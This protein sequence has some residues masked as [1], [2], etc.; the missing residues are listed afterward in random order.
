VHRSRLVGGLA[1]GC[2]ALALLA[3]AADAAVPHTV[4]PGETLWSIAA[5]NNYTTRT[6]AAYNGLSEDAQVY[7]GQ[8]L[9]IPTEGEG[10]AA[11]ASAGSSTSSS[12]ASSTGPTGSGVAHTVAPGESL[13]S[14]ASANGVAESTLASNNGLD[15]DALLI[16]GQTIHIPSGSTAVSSDGIPLGTIPSPYGDLYLRSDAA[17]AWNSMRQESLNTYGQDLYPGGPLSAYRTY[18]QQAQLY[19]AYLDGTGAPANPPGTSEHNLGIAVDVETPEMRWVV[20]QIGGAYGWAK[21]SAPDEWW[22]ITFVG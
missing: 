2:A 18:D 6:V 4:V 3:P 13:W 17:S 15:P 7:V 8:T 12:T 10:A 1:G 22:H 9:Q 14:I 20:D 11:L 19:Q 21:V 16:V 5:A